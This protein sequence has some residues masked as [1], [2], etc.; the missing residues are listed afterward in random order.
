MRKERENLKLALK[1]IDTVSGIVQPFFGVSLRYSVAV[2]NQ[3]V[4]GIKASSELCPG[5]NNS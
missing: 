1:Q 5:M 3:S 4:S 2:R